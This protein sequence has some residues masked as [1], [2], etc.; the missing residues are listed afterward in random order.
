M[1]KIAIVILNWNGKPLLEKFLPSVIRHSTGNDIEIVIVDNGSTDGSIEFLQTFYSICRIIK[2]D[3]NYGFA[4]GYN[5]ALEQIESTYT[6]ILNSDV[7]VTE[8]WLNPMVD[9]LDSHPESAACMPILRWHAHPEM[10][11]YAGAAGGYIDILGFPFCRGRVFQNLEIDKGQY[12][13]NKSI[14]WSSGACTMIRTKIFKELGGFDESFFAHMEEIDLCWRIKNAGH[15]IFCI[16]T[17]VVYHLGGG[18]LPPNNPKKTYLNYRNN[19]LLLL[20][21]MPVFLLLPVFAS[22]FFLDIIQLFRFIFERKPLHSL[23]LFKAFFHFLVRFPKTLWNQY[24]SGNKRSLHPEIYKKS[25]AWS[26]FIL[27]KHTSPY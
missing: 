22:R 16:P 27:R 10:F 23:A 9:F 7:E 26:Y 20:K 25:I 19:Y 14:F 5:K 1:N 4:G 8:N 3:K 12:N 6:V 11:E 13:T 21:N 24:H 17:S 2:L 18:S 15:Q